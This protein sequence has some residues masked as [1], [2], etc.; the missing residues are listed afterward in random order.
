M[1]LIA[2]W[3]NHGT[4]ADYMKSSNYSPFRHMYPLVSPA[5]P[6]IFL[7]RVLTNNRFQLYNVVDGLRYLHDQ[8]VIH[9]DINDVSSVLEARA[10]RVDGSER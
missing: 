2:P 6:L 8:S 10:Y 9:G 5:Y 4:L 1:C 3:M 7:I